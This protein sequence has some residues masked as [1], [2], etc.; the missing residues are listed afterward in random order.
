MNAE[1]ALCNGDDTHQ[2]AAQI[3]VD[4]VSFS[5]SSKGDE[6]ISGI[7]F[8]VNKGEKIGIIGGTGSG[9]TTLINLLPGFYHPNKGNVYVDGK[10]TALWDAEDLK[11]K[12]GI[13]PQKAVL[14]KVVFA[15]I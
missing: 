3:I 6:A 5:Y 13:V 7:S 1:L 4:N 10:N 2:G 8:A 14:S 9:K 15:I 12:Y 11:Q